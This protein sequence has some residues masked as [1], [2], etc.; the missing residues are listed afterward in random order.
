MKTRLK[1]TMLYIK[2][3]FIII[4]VGFFS[5]IWWIITGNNFVDKL[6]KNIFIK[7]RKLEDS[8]INPICDECEKPLSQSEIKMEMETCDDCLCPE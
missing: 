8:M 5:E 4:V 3:G 6:T 1:I 7:I 2:G